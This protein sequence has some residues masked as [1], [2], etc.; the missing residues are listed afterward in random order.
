MGKTNLN[1]ESPEFGTFKQ[2]HSRDFCGEHHAQASYQSLDVRLVC[3]LSLVGISPWLRN[4]DGAMDRLPK[5]LNTTRYRLLALWFLF[6]SF[7]STFAVLSAQ[8][9]AETR[10]I[11]LLP[12]PSLDRRFKCSFVSYPQ[13]SLKTLPDYWAS[14][15]P[16]WAP[17]LMTLPA[18][19]MPIPL[20][21]KGLSTSRGP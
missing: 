17:S 15:S 21:R 16:T 19:N 6:S 4:M 14:T 5:E 13:R 3:D 1:A 7:L 9:F 20:S 2:T 18:T 11:T 12:F 10:T 8:S